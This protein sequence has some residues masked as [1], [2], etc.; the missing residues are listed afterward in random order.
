M[1]L[2]SSLARLFRRKLLFLMALAFVAALGAA[3]A[4]GWSWSSTLVIGVAALVI[5]LF[6]ILSSFWIWVFGNLGQQ[7]KP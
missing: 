3:S 6:W 2:T 7:G 5:T 4:N 1:N